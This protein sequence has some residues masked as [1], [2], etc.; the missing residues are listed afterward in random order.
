L[1]HSLFDRSTAL[2]FIERKCG[3]VDK[4]RNV[5]MIAG[6]S[7]DGPSITMAHQNHRPA[8]RVNC[9]LRVFLVVGVGGLRGLRYRHLVAIILEDVSDGFPPGAVGESTMH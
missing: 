7:D 9:G 4:R 2:T 3:N 8:Y 6:L 5:W 1:R